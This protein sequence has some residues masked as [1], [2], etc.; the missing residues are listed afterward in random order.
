MRR[1][2]RHDPLD[3]VGLQSRRGPGEL[4]ASTV[5]DDDEAGVQADAAQAN[6]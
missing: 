1:R 6:A 2:H 5:P 4:T 3:E